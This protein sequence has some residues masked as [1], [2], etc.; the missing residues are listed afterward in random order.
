MTSQEMRFPRD[1]LITTG[2][3][4]QR[5]AGA[6]QASSRTPSRRGRIS[7]PCAEAQ[8]LR[9][10]LGAHHD[11]DILRQL[12]EDDRPL[13]HWRSQLT[14]LIAARQAAHA[15][16]AMRLAGRLLAEK[17]KAFLQRLTSLWEHYAEERDM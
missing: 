7:P 16:A 4:R 9:D 2:A 13:A 11:L 1:N 6:R 8:R 14:P 10:R 15:S 3:A 12:T 5:I 17:P